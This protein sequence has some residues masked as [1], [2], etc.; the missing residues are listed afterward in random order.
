MSVLDVSG[1][2]NL[3]GWQQLPPINQ[4]PQPLHKAGD[5]TEQAGAKD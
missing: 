1:A 4:P 3:L 2:A 5:E